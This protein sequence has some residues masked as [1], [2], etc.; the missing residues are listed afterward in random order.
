VPAPDTSQPESRIHINKPQPLLDCGR[1]APKRC[2]GDT[3]DVGADI[4]RDGHEIVRAVVRFRA[5]SAA[6]GW[7]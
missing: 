3:V 5:A 6:G 2:V 4:F 7:T 1:Y